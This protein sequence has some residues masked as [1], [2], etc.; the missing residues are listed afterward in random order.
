MN[1]VVYTAIFG[2]INDILREPA[3][4][5]SEASFVAFIE[6]NKATINEKTAF[7]KWKI[8]APVYQNTHSR[9]QA[10]A[11]KVL[12]HQLFKNAQYTLWLDGCFQLVHTNIFHAL[13][14]YLKDSDICVFR[15]RSRKCVYDELTACIQQRKDDE[16]TMIRQVARYAK[17][18]Y[19]ANNGL[20]ETTAVLRR[21]SHAVSEF[22]EMWW[23][24]I[25]TGSLRDQL[26][27][28]YVAWKLGIKY[29]VF[30]GSIDS[31]PYFDWFRH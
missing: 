12:S 10:R 16:T 14:E 8:S 29:N 5:E 27:F 11:H 3:N 13:E 4:Q 6:N 15:H 21:N 9:R 7:P 23:R 18:K 17:E 26:S 1:N 30:E 25:E 31:N 28:D 20:A 2:D 24:E 19:P 22:N